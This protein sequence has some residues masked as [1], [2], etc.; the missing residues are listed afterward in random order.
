MNW[1]DRYKK[2][3][4]ESDVSFVS[5]SMT[6]SADAYS[7]VNMTFNGTIANVYVNGELRGTREITAP[8]EYTLGFTMAGTADVDT[9]LG[10]VRWEQ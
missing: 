7:R 2:E 8:R 3:A 4:V 10:A 1:R 6:I 9:L 5:S